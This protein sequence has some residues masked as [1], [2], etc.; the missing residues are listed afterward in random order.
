MPCDISLSPEVLNQMIGS[1][2]STVPT[3]SIYIFG[4]Y[5]RNEETRDSDIDIYVVTDKPG[6][7][8]I[9]YEAMA[10]VGMALRWMNRPKDILC[11]SK[12]EF[13]RRSERNTGL[14]RVVAKE[15]VKIYER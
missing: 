7:N 6:S 2:V 4:S 8:R 11:L 10:D 9:D 14:E 1:I 12:D 13:I 5:A 3:N 15:G